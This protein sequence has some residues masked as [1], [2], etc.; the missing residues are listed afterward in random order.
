MDKEL[1]TEC[2]GWA[3][4]GI[5]LATLIRQIVKQATA[6]HPETISTWLFVGQAAAST[7]FIIY[8]VLVGNAIFVVTNGCLLLTALAGQW[9]SRRKRKRTSATRW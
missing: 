7:L 1:L 9:V 6:E 5:L 8:S 2:V 4:S 3:A